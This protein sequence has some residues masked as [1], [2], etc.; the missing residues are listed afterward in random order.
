MTTDVRLTDTFSDWV[1]GLR[2]KRAAAIILRRIERVKNGNLGD[3]KAIEG[4]LYELRLNVGPG[5]R[6]YLWRASPTA[7]LIVLLCGGVKGSQKRDIARAWK[8]ATE[9]DHDD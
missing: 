1:D 8:M 2:D 7:P 9:L 3:V 6:V 5:Y 4:R